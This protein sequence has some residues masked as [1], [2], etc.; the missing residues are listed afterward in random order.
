MS[1]QDILT[2]FPLHT[3]MQSQ[4]LMRT[5]HDLK[6]IESAGGGSTVYDSRSGFNSEKSDYEYA[7]HPSLP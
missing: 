3:K 2:V 6:M 1:E 7:S 5:V 4:S